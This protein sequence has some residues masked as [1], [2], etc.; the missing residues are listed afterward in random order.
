MEGQCT[1]RWGRLKQCKTANSWQ[2]QITCPE[3]CVRCFW[4]PGLVQCPQGLTTSNAPGLPFSLGLLKIRSAKSDHGGKMPLGKQAEFG[5]A[6]YAGVDISYAHDIAEH[7][8]VR[9]WHHESSSSSHRTPASK[10]TLRPITAGLPA[11]RV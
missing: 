9:Y 4:P 11:V 10:H 8:Q 5:D 7:M 2:L 3:M 6:R 1:S